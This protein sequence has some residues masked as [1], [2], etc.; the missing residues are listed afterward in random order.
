MTRIACCCAALLTLA[1]SA[2]AQT[3]GT[4]TATKGP[5]PDKQQTHLLQVGMIVTAEGVA[6]QGIVA[7][8][9]VPIDWPEQEVKEVRR[10]FDATA[11]DV[12]Y[13]Q[14]GATAKQMAVTMPYIAPGDSCKAIVVYEIKRTSLLPP[15]DTSIFVKPNLKK[16]KSDIRIY[17]GPSP[18]IESN[19]PKIKLLAK[20]ITKDSTN[21]WDR[22][23]LIY[24][25]TRKNI[26][27]INGPL[28]NVLQTLKDGRGDSEELSSVFVA[29]CRAAEV[30]ARLV[31]VSCPGHCY[32][33]FY[34]EDADGQGYWI[35]CRPAG[36]REFGGIEEFRPII[37][38]GDNFIVPERPKDRLRFINEHLTGS[39]GAPTVK[40][41][42]D[43]TN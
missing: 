25:W 20:D 2:S 26:E 31:F 16:L 35:P 37:Q 42:R 11:R 3:F 12:N 40:F 39:G 10:E 19:S 38:K 17:L 36:N 14:I 13:K 9:Q 33:E 18:N 29:I 21:A 1:S 4:P 27:F 23:E 24:D 15:A 22:V 8:A 34:L 43:L 5:R 28:K 32:A 41:V 6:C 7:S 30:P